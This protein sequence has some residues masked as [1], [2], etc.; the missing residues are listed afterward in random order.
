MAITINGSGTLSGVTAGLTAASMP[1][2]SVV[3]VVQSFSGV[4]TQTT[5]SDTSDA[6]SCPAAVTITPTSSSNKILIMFHG[7][8]KFGNQN[9]VAF[10][11]LR[12][13]TIIGNSTE[14][15]ENTICFA[16]DGQ[17]SQYDYHPQVV[18]LN[19]LDS[20]STTSATTYTVKGMG[21][22][23]TKSAENRA[24]AVAGPN[25]NQEFV[26]GGSSSTSGAETLA[27]NMVMI[28]QEIKA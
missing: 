1:T 18:S 14:T 27:G 16:A 2:G 26:W 7:S 20:P 15:T 3:Q 5:S 10:W 22:Q 24:L 25:N 23:G 11:L 4:K 8:W 17:V 28:A 21:I 6:L 9:D 19:Y 12:G 13:S